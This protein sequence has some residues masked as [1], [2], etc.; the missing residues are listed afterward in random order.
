MRWLKILFE[1]L[2]GFTDGLNGQFLIAHWLELRAIEPG[3]QLSYADIVPVQVIGRRGR[4]G[5][6][7]AVVAGVV[8]PDAGHFP[9]TAGSAKPLKTMALPT[10]MLG[11][12]K[13]G[14][15]VARILQRHKLAS[16]RQWNRIVEQPFPAF[17]FTRRDWRL[18]G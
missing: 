9:D 1:N 14:D 18:P 10:G 2:L 5:C 12:G 15:V 16:V 13:L 7:M 6:H 17:G 8:C 4:S 3:V 11:L